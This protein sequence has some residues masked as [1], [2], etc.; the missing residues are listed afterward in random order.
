VAS[1]ERRRRAREAL[2]MVHI[3]DL[4]HR[5][6]RQ[7]SGGQQQR[8]ALARAVVINPDILLLDEPLSALDAKIR[9][10][11]RAE[12]SRLLRQFGITAV[13]V[14]RDQAEAMVLGDRVVVMDTGRVMQV[15]VP[16]EIF[17]RPAAGFIGTANVLP[18]RFFRGPGPH[19]IDL[20]FGRLPLGSGDVAQ[21]W[22]HLGDGAVRVFFRAPAS[23]IVPPEQSHLESKPSRYF[24][25]G[26]SRQT[27]SFVGRG[28][29]HH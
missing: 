1:A 15:G 21:R 13:Y 14:T 17:E 20:G 12:L 6:I 29:A 4:V 9:E 28:Y 10:D 24:S 11:L 7:L 23:D 8:V 19:A 16:M 5:R 2:E 3:G 27:S 22:A 18:G 25:L 26:R